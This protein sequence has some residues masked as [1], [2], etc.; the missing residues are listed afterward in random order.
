MEKSEEI[1]MRGRVKFAQTVIGFLCYVALVLPYSRRTHGLRQLDPQRRHLL[2]CNHVSLLDSLLLGGLCWWSGCYPILVLGDKKVWHTSWVKKFLSRQTS[3][4]VERGRMNPR[5][6]EELEAFGRAGKEFQLIVF[7]EGTRG[8]GV[9]VAECQ[10]G[11]FYIA[12]AAR[13][14]LVPVFFE[15]MQ[16]VSTK[17]G[18]FHPLGGLRKIETHIGAPIAP[19]EYLHLT[20][21]EFT[22]FVRT[23]IAA[24]GKR[25]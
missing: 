16:L 21:D 18:R 23:K 1:L 2:V 20:R 7:P 17:A 3:F 5:R 24:L 19:E 9:D 6:I 11:I 10:P 22:E 13:L 25:T 12:Q 14:P 8:N 15:N 4:L